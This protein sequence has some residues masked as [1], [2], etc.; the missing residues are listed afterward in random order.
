MAAVDTSSS[1]GKNPPTIRTKGPTMDKKATALG[2]GVGLLSASVLMVELLLTRLFSVMLY[3]HFAFLAVSIS[4]LGLGTGGVWIYLRGQR[5]SPE[6]LSVWVT[7]LGLLLAWS[8]LALLIFVVNLRFTTDLSFG[9][10]A[11]PILLFVLGALP[12]VFAGA[13][14]S[15]V[16]WRFA[17]AI[18]RLYFYDL[19]GAALGSLAV[20]P[21]L[22]WVG[23]PNGML[24]AALL[25]SGGTLLIGLAVGSA[26]I[27]TSC[28]GLTLLAIV[29]VLIFNIRGN[30]ID[31]R[32]AKGIPTEDE[33]YSAW[34][35]ISR[36][37]LHPKAKGYLIKID[38]EA[39]TWVSHVDFWN[40]DRASIANSFAQRADDLAHY[41]RPGAKTLVIGSGGG[42]DVARALAY[43]SPR[44]VAVDINPLI[45]RELMQKRLRDYSFRLF[46]RPE[47]ELIVDDARS[48][49]QRSTERFDVIQST[50]IDTWAST[51]A[52]AFAMSESYLYTVQAFEAYLRHLTPDGILSVTRFEFE[53]PRQALR[54]TALGRAAMERMGVSSPAANFMA[55]QQPL[56]D[57][58]EVAVLMKRTPFSSAEIAAVREFVAKHAELRTVYLP[59]A[60]DQGA[61]SALL[62]SPDL[63]AFAAKYPF[64]ISPVGDSRPF[65]FFTARWPQ[66]F[67]VFG[68][69]GEDVKNNA[70]LF[71]LV[72]LAV[73]TGLGILFLLFLPGALARGTQLPRVSLLRWAYFLAL[74]IAFIIVEVVLIQTFI[75][76]LGHPTYGITIAVFSLL[77]GSGLGSRW[78]NRIVS[79]HRAGFEVPL[80]LAALLTVWL[81]ILLPQLV[82]YAQGFSRLIRG[83]ISIGVILPVAF[84]MGIPF[85]TGVRAANETDGE[86]LP[87]LWSAN[88]AG[89][90]FGSVTAILSAIAIGIPLTGIV[91]AA[92]YLAAAAAAYSLLD[93]R[94]SAVQRPAESLQ[95]PGTS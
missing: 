80:L 20:I 13:L 70:S 5:I 48:A 10:V 43:N 84:L 25:A 81:G 74:G 52:G 17:S 58:V 45:A 30:F 40:G 95:V 61:F 79:P 86:A 31:V 37:C 29:L 85:P 68:M 39:S 1:S 49:I 38:C 22:Q 83:V 77:V 33:V 32:Y 66:I 65:F 69:E 35:A 9:T 12:F 87:W 72:I 24:V 51:A 54:V 26:R 76:F 89:S 44:V 92:F 28:A 64:D 18:H 55:V 78:S 4:M 91:A 7:N 14:L 6:G 23:A 62:R 75:L 11:R 8:I 15:L 16:V 47:V 57:S 3:Y 73:L 19:T 71:I 21:V 46:E 67:S 34:N 82:A 60:P 59:D 41:L 63:P 56:V 36:V 50:L 53:V 88:A 42:Q 94:T 2:L 90:V 27:R 93:Q